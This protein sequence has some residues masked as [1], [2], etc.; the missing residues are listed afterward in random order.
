MRFRLQKPSG[1][2]L[3]VPSAAHT[4][5]HAILIDLDGGRRK[6]QRCR[7]GLHGALPA[8]AGEAM[9]RERAAVSVA[10]PRGVRA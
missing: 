2:A 1:D 5:L 9:A 10:Q 8:L 4:Y 7:R 6:R 3:T